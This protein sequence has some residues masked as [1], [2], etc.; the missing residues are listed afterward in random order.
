MEV[1]SKFNSAFHGNVSQEEITQQPCLDQSHLENLQ[2]WGLY[3]DP[4]VVP[5]NDYSHC[6][7]FLIR[8][9][10]FSGVNCPLSSPC[11]SSWRDSVIPLECLLEH[12]DEIPPKPSPLQGDGTFSQKRSPAVPQ[13]SGLWLC[14]PRTRTLHLCLPNFIQLLFPAAPACPGP[15]WHVNLTT[16]LES[17][18]NKAKVRS[19]WPPRSFVDLPSTWENESLTGSL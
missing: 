17:S 1:T 3:S 15:S 5:V 12:C 14:H 7:N 8:D 13:R 11:C 4:E 16:S 9:E 18:A 2:R 6:K 19:I 10:T